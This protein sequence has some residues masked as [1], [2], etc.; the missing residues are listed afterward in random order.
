MSSHHDE[1]F[2]AHPDCCSYMLWVSPF[3]QGFGSH[4]SSHTVPSV[5]FS[6][7]RVLTIVFGMGTGVSPGRIATKNSGYSVIYTARAGPDHLTGVRWI[8]SL[9]YI[10]RLSHLR[11]QAFH[12]RQPPAVHS[13]I[14]NQTVKQPLLF[15][16]ERR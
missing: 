2:F 9:L 4:L 7:V 16:L 15:S 3:F 10:L 14:D 6:A 11:K 13:L 1:Q 8:Q 5:V 12:L